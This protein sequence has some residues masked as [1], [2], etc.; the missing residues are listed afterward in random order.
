MLHGLIAVGKNISQTNFISLNGSL[1]VAQNTHCRQHQNSQR[2]CSGLQI[3]H[4]TW[5]RHTCSSQF[6]TREAWRTGD[7]DLSSNP[8]AVLWFLS[9]NLPITSQTALQ[10]AS[11]PLN[12]PV[13]SPNDWRATN[14]RSVMCLP[15]TQA[16][17]I[18]SWLSRA[19]P[20]STRGWVI[21]PSTKAAS[22][23]ACPC[24][25]GPSIH[26]PGRSVF[27]DYRRYVD[28]AVVRNRPTSPSRSEIPRTIC[29]RERSNRVSRKGQVDRWIQH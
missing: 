13:I 27:G 22:R 16:D 15:E 5:T 2:K 9:F 7:F 1:A 17:F 6:T 11:A 24:P 28:T 26:P 12:H 4:V 14:P 19:R 29:A 25:A 10:P 21:G 8:R 20:R 3:L 23:W 18:T